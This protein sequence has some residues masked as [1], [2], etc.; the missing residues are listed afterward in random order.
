MTLTSP[1]GTGTQMAQIPTVTEDCA[2]CAI[3]ASV[4]M[5]LMARSEG[6]G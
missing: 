4:F 6:T 1:Y 3:L 5:S 2:I